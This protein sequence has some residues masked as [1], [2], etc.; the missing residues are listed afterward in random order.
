LVIT[1][2]IYHHE[3][4]YRFRAFCNS[5]AQF[6]MTSAKTILFHRVYHRF[7]G[8]HL[9]F[10][11]YLDHV[12]SASWAR[13]HIYV[14]PSSNSNHL[15]QE[16]PGLVATYNP[17]KADILF[18]AGTDWRALRAYPGID[19]HKTIINLIQGVRH[20]NP[21][22]EL[23]SY[24][25]HKAVRICVSQ[26]VANA[27][28]DTGECNGP[29]HVIP[30][31]IDLD[32]LPLSGS[33]PQYDV[34]IAGLKQP[35]LANELSDRLLLRGI[36][37][38]CLT[39]QIPRNDYLNRISLARIV[40]ALPYAAEGFYLPA[41]E[42]MAMGISLICPDCIGNRSF[43]Q[44][45]ITCLMP[46]LDP[47]HIE[48]SVLRL[49]NNAMLATDLRTNALHQSRFYDTIRERQAFL[50]ILSDHLASC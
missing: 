15:W 39:Q 28:T 23:Y 26:E 46:S 45:G 48:Q 18:I 49:L 12:S 27:I 3:T 21:K 11:D 4:T 41:L 25:Q 9:K 19:R 1:V 5:S 7:T 2:S 32:K 30:N 14:D 16:H 24:L 37:V 29:I 38:D 20:A 43:C 13:A 50:Q 34:F 8:G 6:E 47:V 44:D 22:H 36:S 31:G 10:N 40:V 42:V 17:D 33:S 35:A